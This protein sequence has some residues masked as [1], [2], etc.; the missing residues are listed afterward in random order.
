MVRE[1][2][3]GSGMVLKGSRRVLEDSEKGL[4]RVLEQRS[5]RLSRESGDQDPNFWNHGFI[6]ETETDTFSSVD[7]ISGMRL[8]VFLFCLNFETETETISL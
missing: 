8:R 6:V 4:W 7:S 5:L 2:Q 3:G 1:G